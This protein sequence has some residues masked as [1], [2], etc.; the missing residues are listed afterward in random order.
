MTTA[1]AQVEVFLTALSALPVDVRLEII[2][3]SLAAVID[4]SPVSAENTMLA[5]EA[6]IARDW[7]TPEED[8][9]WANLNDFILEPA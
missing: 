1:Q 3:R 5:G 9:A 7:D 4:L 8:E 6:V 2:R